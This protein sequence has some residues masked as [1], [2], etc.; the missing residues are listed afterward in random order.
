MKTIFLFSIALVVSGCM[1]VVCPKECDD[2]T[3]E[4]PPNMEHQTYETEE[5][6]EGSNYR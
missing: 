3:I 2:F 5:H 1:T 6:Q 4:S